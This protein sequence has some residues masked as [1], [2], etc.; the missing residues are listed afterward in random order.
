MGVRL[1][2]R[3]REEP[4][5]GELA[6]VYSDRSATMSDAVQRGSDGMDR[7]PSPHRENWAAWVS[8]PV[9]WPGC[10]AGRFRSGAEAPRRPR[11]GRDGGRLHPAPIPLDSG[12]P[13]DFVHRLF[14]FRSSP[15]SSGTDYQV[16]VSSGCSLGAGGRRWRDER[17]ARGL[18]VTR[19]AATTTVLPRGTV[20]RAYHGDCCAVLTWSGI[21]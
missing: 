9:V 20:D 16:C 1:T 4:P 15:S 18:G 14:R 21:L 3:A 19:A 17:A 11:S 10:I 6:R 12:I 8:L 2:R 5:P 13:R 7:R